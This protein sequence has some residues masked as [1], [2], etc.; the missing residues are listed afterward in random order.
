MGLVKQVFTNKTSVVMMIVM[1]LMMV[2]GSAY[3]NELVDTESVTTTFSDIAKAVGKV[4]AAVAAVAAGIMGI[5]LAWKYG[6]KLFGIIA[7]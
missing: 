3:A 5:I 4:I 7:K 1:A 6:R 2:A